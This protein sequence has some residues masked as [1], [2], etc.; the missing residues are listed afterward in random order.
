M[1]VIS[2]ISDSCEGHAYKRLRGSLE[3]YTRKYFSL[4]SFSSLSFDDSAVMLNCF[5]L[6]DP[7]PCRAL[8]EG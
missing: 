6:A 5:K 7:I 3:Q 2:K 1:K 8:G 4:F